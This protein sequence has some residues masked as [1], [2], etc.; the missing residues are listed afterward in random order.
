MER[1]RQNMAGYR[2]PAYVE[3][4]LTQNY[5]PGFMRMSIIREEDRYAF[6]YKTDSFAKL[7]PSGMRLYDKLLL[8]RNLISMCETNSDHLISAESYLIEPEL[9]YARCGRTDIENLRLMYYPDVKRLDFRYK[10]VI[11]ADR[12][13]NREIREEREMAARIREAAEPGDINRIKMFLEKT[14]SRMEGMPN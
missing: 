7:D 3:E 9:V 6:S 12:I 1:I 8:I 2:M 4:I 11:F 10:I 13:M 14:L 5:C